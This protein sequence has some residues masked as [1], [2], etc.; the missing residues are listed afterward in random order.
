[1]VMG[2]PGREAM[3]SRRSGAAVVAGLQAAGRDPVVVDIEDQLDPAAVPDGAVVFNLVHGTY[4]EDGTLQAELDAAG[5]AYIPA[6]VL[7]PAA[8]AWTSMRPRTCCALRVYR[9]RGD[10]IDFDRPVDPRL[11]RL[12]HLGGYVLKPRNDGSSVGLYMVDSPS[13]LLPTLERILAEVGPL[14]YLL[15][16][17]LRGDEYTVAVIDDAAGQAH[18]QP[19]LRIVPAGDSYDFHAKYEADSTRYEVVE[20]AD[21]ADRLADLGLAAHR[22]CGCR[23]LSRV[24]V[25]ADGDGALHVLEVNTLPGFTDHSLVPKAAAA[26]GTDFS[27]LVCQLVDLAGRRASG[28]TP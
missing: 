26:A 9:W 14:P 18:A 3:I 7:L 20:D 21:L 4:G 11:V 1:M 13:F 22:A 25:M 15:E 12:P 19:P 23:D 10:S 27:T 6:Q 8:C 5:I 24:D 16:E 28:A 2:G 17:R